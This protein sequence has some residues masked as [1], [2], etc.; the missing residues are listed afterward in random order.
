MHSGSWLEGVGGRVSGCRQH[1]V[2]IFR[3]SFPGFSCL[4]GTLG[5]FHFRGAKVSLRFSLGNG[6]TIQEFRGT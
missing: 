2:P 6:S 5:L 4:E 1:L 3:E